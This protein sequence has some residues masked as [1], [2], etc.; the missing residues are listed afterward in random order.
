MCANCIYLLKPVRLHALRETMEPQ[1]I[2][3]LCTNH[4][5]SPGEVREV[6]PCECCRNFEARR[7]RGVRTEPPVPPSPE[8]KY[9]PLSRGQFAI[10]DAADFDWLNQHTWFL[11]GGRA[12]IY[13]ACRAECGKI[14]FMHREI[15]QTPPGLVVDHINHNPIN[16]RRCN[17]RNCTLQENH[18]NRRLVRN[19]SGFVGVYPYGKKWRAMIHSGGKIVYQEVFDDKVEAAKARDRKAY[20][21]YG[22][23]AYLNFPDEIRSGQASPCPGR[24]DRCPLV[25]GSTSIPPALLVQPEPLSQEAGPRYVDVS[26]SAHGHCFARATLTV[27]HAGTG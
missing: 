18:R 16:N 5:E 19:K 11:K 10:V 3:P 27:I 1:L 6:H 20:E 14:I 13:Y 25:E 9:I 2:L 26:G 24:C 8:I 4:A 17:L 23:F 22:P 12:G 21:L 15:M 7:E